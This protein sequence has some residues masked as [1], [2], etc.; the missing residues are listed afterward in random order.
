MIF[1]P[2]K[3]EGKAFAI[4]TKKIEWMLAA[5]RDP[6]EYTEHGK[7]LETFLRTRLS[8]QDSL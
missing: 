1:G 3:P 5:G 6:E 4:T 7:F 2:S 8:F